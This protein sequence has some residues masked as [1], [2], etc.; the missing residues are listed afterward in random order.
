MTQRGPG[1][2]R[3]RTTP[4]LTRRLLPTVLAALLAMVAALLL[5]AGA[6]QAAG[7]ATLSFT[8][9]STITPNPPNTPG[10]LKPGEQFQYNLAI[11][12]SSL[13]EGCVDATITDTLPPQFDATSIP[14]SSSERQVTYDPQT[15]LLTIK[16]TLP[17]SQ[18]AGQFGLPAGSNRT[19]GVGMR[20]PTE[21]DVKE[22]DV[23]TNTAVASA[24]NA[25][26]KESSNPIKVEVP[27]VYRPVATK[28]WSPSS[29]IAQSGAESTITLGARNASSTSAS[30]QKLRVTDDTSAT[31]NAFDVTRLGPVQAYPPGADRIT[32]GVCTKPIGNPCADGEW[33]ES[34][35]QS[36]NGP[37][38]PPGGTPLGSITG[39][40]YTFTNNGG[41]PIPH[42][43]DA[44]LVELGVQ[45]RNTFRNNNQ[46]IQPQTRLT[47]TNEAVPTVI[48]VGDEPING[49]KVTANFAIEPDTIRVQASKNMFADNAGTWN[50]NGAIVV[51]QDSGI[52]MN[53]GAKNIS[54]GPVKT[55]VIDEPS[56]NAPQEFS[57][58]DTTKGRFT[59]PTGATQ[60]TLE[61]ACR[62]GASPAPV[63][64]QRQGAPATVPIDSFGCAPGVFPASIKLTYLGQTQGGDGT[65]VAGSGAQLDLHGNAAGVTDADVPNGLTNCV[66]AYGTTPQSSSAA[67]VACKTVTV[68]K[69]SSGLGNTVKSSSGVTT[70]VPG[71]AMRFDLSFKNNGNVPVTDAY[72][73]DPPDPKAPSCLPVPSAAGCN[74]FSIT[75][76]NSLS[77]SSSPTHVLE[78]FDPTAAGG[79]GAYVPYVSSDAALKERATGIR[80]RITGS[81]PVGATFRVNYTVLVR[82]GV[83]PGS[84]PKFTNCAQVGIGDTPIGAPFCSPEVTVEGTDAG[85]SLQK[86]ITPSSVLRPEPGLPPQTATVKHRIENSGNIYLSALSFTDKET[87]FFDAVDFASA[88]HLNFPPGAN[89]VRVDACTTGCGTDTFING[90]VTGSSTPGLPAGV[91]AA[92]VRGIRVTFSSSSAGYNLLPGHNYPSGGACPD[93]SFC[94]NVTARQFLRGTSTPI[95]ATNTDVS[96]GS[97]QWSGGTIP[98]SPVNA[99]LNITDG[100]AKIKFT[101]GP[102]SR[103][104]PG[105]TAPFDLLMENTGTTAVV[106]PT[107]TDPLPNELI[108][109]ENPPGGSPG[110]PF[111]VSYPALPTGYPQPASVEYT[112]T[113]V[114]NKVTKVQWRFLDA[115]QNPWTLP[116]GGKVN[117]R[118]YVSV[119]APA[120]TV[121]DNE[122]GGH[123]TNQTLTCDPGNTTWNSGDPYPAGVN[124]LDKAAITTLSGNSVQ[125]RKW[126]SGNDALGFYNSVTKQVVPTNDP[127]CPQY[128][129]KGAV[130]TRYPCT[131]IV[132][133]GGTIKYL[134][135]LINTGN[136]KLTKAVAVDGLPVQGDT[137]VLLSQ[138]QRGTQWNN[139]PTMLSPVVVEEGYPGVDTQY[140]DIPFPSANFCTQNLQ[141]A[142]NDN[143]P[144]S[145]FDAL[146]TPGVTGFRTTMDFPGN[147]ALPGGAGVTLT[148]TMQA[149]LTLDTP[150]ADPIAWNSFAQKPTFDVGGEEAA[151]EPPKVGAMMRFNT[152]NITKTVDG[153]PAGLQLPPFPMAYRCSYGGTEIATGAINVVEG[154]TESL[155]MQP[156]GATCA[157]WETNANGGTSP[158]EGEANAAIVTVPD[159]NTTPTGVTVDIQ[160][161]FDQGKITVAKTVTG[162]AKDLPLDPNGTVGGGTFPFEVNCSFNG[163]PVPGLAPLTFDLKAGESKV[164]GKDEELPYPLPA[165]SE[166]SV[167][168]LDNLSSTRTIVTADGSIPAEGTSI[169]AKVK[170]EFEGGSTVGFEN[171]YE[172]GKVTIN[173]SITGAAKQYAKGPFGFEFQ[174]TFGGNTLQPIAAQVTKPQTPSDTWSAEVTPLPV[175]AACAVYETDA[176]DSTPTQPLPILIGNVIVP[177]D[178]A[179]PVSVSPDN[180][181]PAGYVTINKA[182]SGAAASL[183]PDAEFELR[184]QC[185][186]G[187][188]IILD[189][190][191]TLKAGGS[192]LITDPLP[193][194]AE[195]W[196]TETT[197]GGATTTVIDYPDPAD[198][199]KVT[200]NTPNISITATNTFDAASLT[201]AK[202]TTGPAP[203]GQTFGFTVACTMPVNSASPT[204]TYEVVL[205]GADAAF[206][207]LGGAS[208]TISVPKGATCT[209]REV[210]DGGAWS[211]D[212]APTNGV[213]LID[214]PITVTATN[215]YD[216]GSVAV[217]K[218]T[219]G[220]A[221]GQV[222][223]ATFVMHVVCTDSGGGQTLVD[224][225]V[226][227]KAGATVTLPDGLP[228]GAKCWATE[229]ATGGATASSVDHD[230]PATAAVVTQQAKALTLTATNRFDAGSVVVAKRTTGIA[231]AG[232]T[233]KFTLKCT[234]PTGLTGGKYP[235]TL[236]PGDSAFSLKAGQSRT[237][238]VPKGATCKTVETASNGAKTVTYTDATGKINNGITVSNPKGTVVVTNGFPTGPTACPLTVVG[239]SSAT[240]LNPN[241][242]NLV[243]SSAKTSSACQIV[244]GGG[245]LV[246]GVIVKCA[247]TNKSLRGD[248]K[249]CR[250]LIGPNGAVVVRPLGYSNLL[251]SVTITATPKPGVKNY[252]ATTW[253]RKWRTS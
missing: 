27:V 59:W 98:L 188:D 196:A 8:K 239:L 122:A 30:V 233:Y 68:Q 55:L 84:N 181:F 236:P 63:V 43:A 140:T 130:Y 247:P 213:V 178:S 29:A 126:S 230:S 164:I 173:K 153:I 86:L 65:I 212:I 109:D 146:F 67:S 80:V 222:T 215:N 71:Q 241:G 89:R 13:V 58:I 249:Y 132:D 107:I 198:A 157:I 54:A 38:S 251:V 74:P 61:V 170:P 78:V 204:P 194:G 245:T 250:T 121:V 111:V 72:I 191:E 66:E 137:G 106:D 11:G 210:D 28:T 179:P 96:T 42:S 231:P 119:V 237:V 64:I 49:P 94:F 124:C 115:Q 163:A 91:A 159:P 235:V 100:T 246:P 16:F 105:D 192:T 149:P 139:R 12:C 77:A 253:T 88:M 244:T 81:L 85:A 19:I 75:R 180:T 51:G 234:M 48:T 142:P 186:Q 131:A 206:T 148:W 127:S 47:I 2:R 203:S 224:K 226:S 9:S 242:N 220:A 187:A 176:G 35:P 129:F 17:L 134:I 141:P 160:N 6:A 195:C 26:P 189:K 41:A 5:P 92:D 248:L 133:P 70:I 53:L 151:T 102:D 211:T 175:G 143:C 114:N 97:G 99:D 20:L 37:F 23:I 57:K 252:Q 168:E 1:V 123:G 227:V 190:T 169:D 24:T 3:P 205:P 229:T 232:A 87:A 116:P 217:A 243:V 154:T 199:I 118:I 238:A 7:T 60:A 166:C 216:T 167:T 103:I 135:S 155:P 39:V 161:R 150:N 113:V 82:D 162:G 136:N 138:D 144:N 101:K 221:A 83:D 110:R 76:L 34:A 46:P 40:R 125:T 93:A 45:L 104:A 62:S 223:Q 145:A 201:V 185:Q 177:A 10:I 120:G 158:N 174:C 31:F 183:V 184:V 202:Q 25:D 117:V 50:A 90:A 22:G 209:V 73:V 182:T 32:V 225:S 165:G 147:Q 207:L 69:P 219:T 200:P 197:N 152:V 240:P 4:A 14:S 208:K 33:I 44:G 36:G 108:L 128:T 21:T 95:P 79:A 218:V 52:T 228:L 172:A 171:V 193:M 214:G 156:T 15:R 56:I 112:P 18:P